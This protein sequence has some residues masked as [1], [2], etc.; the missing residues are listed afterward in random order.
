[1]AYNEIIISAISENG[2]RSGEKPEMAAAAARRRRN[3]SR[4]RGVSGA[5][6]CGGAED[7]LKAKSIGG[8]MKAG[9]SEA[10]SIS[11]RQ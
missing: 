1:M 7:A 10:K 11:Q 6:P 8:V 5:A 3:G 4:H 9:E 2:W